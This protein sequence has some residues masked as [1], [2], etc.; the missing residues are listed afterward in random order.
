MICPR[1]QTPNSDEDK[2]CEQCGAPLPALTQPDAMDD[3]VSGPTMLAGPG[4]PSV[5]VRLGPDGGT[6]YPLGSRAVVGRL[7]SCD[8]P[9]NDK[10]V[11][12]EHARLSRLRDGYVIEDLGSTN[13]TLVNGRRINEAVLLRP[14]DRV[15]IGSVDFR[16]DVEAPAQAEPAHLETASTMVM[17]GPTSPGA[18]EAH[19]PY[20]FAGAPRDSTDAPTMHEVPPVP[21]TFPPLEPFASVPEADAAVPEPEPQPAQPPPLLPPKPPPVSAVPEPQETAVPTE[22]VAYEPHVEVPPP[23]PAS[24]PTFESPSAASAGTTGSVGD[25]ATSLAARLGTLLTDLTRELDEHKSAV[26]QLQQRVAELEE[27]EQ[28]REALKALMREVPEP[29]MQKEQLQAA[30]DM[31][32]TLIQNPRDVAVLMQ[33]GEQAPGLAAV[34]NEYGQLRRVLDRFGRE[35]GV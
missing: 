19:P 4:A 6:P 27:S 30:Q 8:V 33:M 14:G 13:G 20:P 10:S 5:L 26:Q 1:C 18:A 15:T 25:D 21:V 3:H 7:E 29:S 31:L 35:L 11:S 28:A 9:V 24:A 16:Y 2:F 17:Q 23:V 22:P 12:R 34:V 32:D